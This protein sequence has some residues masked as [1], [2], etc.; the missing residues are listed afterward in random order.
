M[1]RLLA[2]LVAMLVF[3][4][5]GED[6]ET[7]AARSS[8][9]AAPVAITDDTG[10]RIELDAPAERVVTIEWDHTENALALGVTPVGAGDTEIYRDWVAAGPA[11]PEQTESV[12]TRSEPSLEKIAALQ[13]D[14]IIGS[15]E[16]VLK[17]REKLERIAPLVVFD[18]FVDPAEYRDGAEWDRMVDQFER[19]AVLLGAEDKADELLAGVERDVEAAR[20]RIED[21][22]AAGDAVA[23]AQGFTS[24]KPVSRLYD[25]GAWLVEI[26]R[27]V[28]LENAY[29][30]ERQEWGITQVG[31]EGM[32]QVGDADWLLTMALEGDDPF[33]GP[34]AQ[35]PAWQRLPVVEAD[36]V[37]AI[38]ADTWP[39]GGPLSAA[40]TAKRYADAVTSG[41]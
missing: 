20:A 37:R 26:A 35:N 10:T 4:G 34:W 28:G 30:G 36:H 33:A 41:G 2:A 27:R 13:P 25:D 18:G 39:W 31:L 16:G 17:S 1:N 24:G 7:P 29:D 9:E 3:A 40:L 8:P 5:C 22:G 11:I 23:L 12:G 15:R 38:G 21:A 6:E 32:R 19:T 14:L